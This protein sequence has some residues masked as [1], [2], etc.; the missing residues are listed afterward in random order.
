MRGSIERIENTGSGTE[1][2]AQNGSGVEGGG[3]AFD[4]VAE[5]ATTEGEGDGQEP[6]YSLCGFAE[7]LPGFVDGLGW[8]ERFR[9][10][11]WDGFE[12]SVDGA[13]PHDALQA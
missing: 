7:E 2:G 13:V 6:G 12:N 3:C 11:R 5:S 8:R 4:G 1:C 10:R 9:L